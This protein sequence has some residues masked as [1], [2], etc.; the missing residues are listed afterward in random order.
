MAPR[1]NVPLSCADV[2]DA[3]SGLG[4]NGNAIE[5]DTLIVIGAAGAD[6]G[7]GADLGTGSG[8]LS[9]ASLMLAKIFSTRGSADTMPSNQ[10]RPFIAQR[11]MK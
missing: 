8:P 6:P 5:G 10:T 4:G 2:F 9:I 3:D 1:I 7:A 11:I